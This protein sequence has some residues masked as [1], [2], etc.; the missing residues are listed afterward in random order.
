[1]I[2][3]SVIISGG[4]GHLGKELCRLFTRLKYRVLSVQR[5][6]DA[7]LE[8]LG[9]TQHLCSLEAL[10]SDTPQARKYDLA[11]HTAAKTDLWGQWGDYLR[12]NVEGTQAFFRFAKASGVQTFIYTSTPSV[13]FANQDLSNG[14]ESLSYAK[15]FLSPYPKSKALAEKWV[16]NQNCSQLKT[17]ALR[18]PLIY[19][20]EDPHFLPRILKL[21]KRGFLP[22][23][24]NGENEVGVCQV[25]NAASAHQKLFQHAKNL[26][27]GEA[28][29]IADKSV[30]LWR[31]VASLVSSQRSE[32]KKI[33][34]PQKF[35]Y[36]LGWFL[37]AAY[38]FFR[39]E[40][41]PPLTRFIV[42]NLS[43][44][45]TFSCQKARRD[46]GF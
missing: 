24:G 7:E 42:L 31:F 28:Y 18:P 37:E 45:R 4:T 2:K 40:S 19:G 39:I 13:V 9:V 26:P 14:D 22:I 46:F 8:S 10:E 20:P 32:L 6:F 33:Y 15:N 11:I 36:G 3:G 43:C 30:N 44:H 5:T 23:I 27:G 38:K 1:M 34:L 35:C 29:F 12:I 25:G 41:C 16:L 17:F 21:T